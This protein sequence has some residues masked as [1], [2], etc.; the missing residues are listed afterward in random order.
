M[1][2][3]YR[4]HVRRLHRAVRP[5]LSDDGEAEEVVQEAF[6]KAFSALERYRR[7]RAR[8]VSWLLTIAL[9]TARKRL[10]KSGKR[11]IPTE[12]KALARMTDQRSANASS[13]FGD[14]EGDELRREVLLQALSEL[15][16]RDREIIT[17]RYG[18]ELSVAEV[19]QLCKVRQANVRKICQRQRERLLARIREIEAQGIDIRELRST[20]LAPTAAENRP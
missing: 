4:L 3:L 9:N 6:I 18:A 16:P 13:S 20:A 1:S 17:L 10:R 5:M 15:S 14:G 19:G 7:Q 8:F 2:G 11:H 12:P